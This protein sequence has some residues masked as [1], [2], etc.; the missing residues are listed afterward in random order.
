MPTGIS[1]LDEVWQ[2][3]TGCS[4]CS[5]GCDHCYA[6]TMAQTGRLRNH[7]RYRGLA[8]TVSGPTGLDV[9]KWTG[10]V[11]CNEEDLTQPLQWRKRR[12]IG[13][14][15]M[16][17]LFHPAVPDA[18][19]D[20][21]FAVMALCPQHQ[22]VVCTKRAERMREYM[23]TP[24]RVRDP[25]WQ[26]AAATIQRTLC[27]E[28]AYLFDFPLPNL[29]LGVTV[30][31]NGQMERV[32]LLRETPAA[33]RWISYEPLL[34]LATPIGGDG[35]SG[36]VAGCESGQNRRRCR[37]DWVRI[38]GDWCDNFDVKF[39]IKQL[40]LDGKVVTDPALFPAD[41]RSR[42]LPWELNK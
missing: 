30:E 12:T 16:G 5:P 25:R 1:Y 23:T 40:S 18:F 20:K 15:F 42:E 38:I 39:Y 24:S 4:P 26:S 36:V 22:F 2:V 28:G 19:L 41:F 7:R 11:R 37:L 21:V 29:H 31:S 3:V 10:E 33:H 14:V 13:T 17:D 6:A 8:T 32:R 34:G 9:G 27:F 35:I